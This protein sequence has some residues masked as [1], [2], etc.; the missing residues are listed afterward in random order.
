MYFGRRSLKSP[1][2]LPHTSALAPK[3]GQFSGPSPPF[4]LGG[5][6][7][8]K[9][10][11][12]GPIQDLYGSLTLPQGIRRLVLYTPV[13]RSSLQPLIP[14]VAALSDLRDL[15]LDHRRQIKTLRDLM[16]RAS[17]HPQICD[18]YSKPAAAALFEPLRA[19]KSLRRVQWMAELKPESPTEQELVRS[20]VPL[21]HSVHTVDLV[22]RSKIETEGRADDPSAS[23]DLQVR[24]GAEQAGRGRTRNFVLSFL[25]Q[26]SQQLSNAAGRPC[27][28]ATILS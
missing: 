26:G 13:H 16:L 27:R 19:C 28:F 10:L 12:L 20:L 18:C 21:F 23:R 17:H 11:T 24:I 6:R 2:S 25:R 1:H 3:V 4:D 8:L 22:L 14:K 15:I 7:A 5:L 9:E